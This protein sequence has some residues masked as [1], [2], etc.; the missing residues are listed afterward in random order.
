VAEIDIQEKRGQPMWAW[1]LGILALLVLAGVIWA[2]TRNGDRVDDRAMERDTVPATQMPNSGV[3]HAAD[4]VLA[5]AMFDE[6]PVQ[7]APAR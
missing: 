2:V 4:A 7:F 1:I 3:D 5:Y 6:T